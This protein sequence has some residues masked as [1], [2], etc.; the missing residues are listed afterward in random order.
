MIWKVLCHP[1]HRSA[2][3]HPASVLWGLITCAAGGDRNSLH[4]ST[5]LPAAAVCSWSQNSQQQQSHNPS[6]PY[7]FSNW[8]LQV[9]RKDDG[10]QVCEGVCPLQHC[11]SWCGSSCQLHCLTHN[12]PANICF[13]HES[14]AVVSGLQEGDKPAPSCPHDLSLL[15]LPPWCRWLPTSLTA[16]QWTT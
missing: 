1:W 5:R 9:G 14:T 16:A 7:D 6:S 4:S 3:K 13:I 10:D 12:N 8:P 11:L 2:C 15:T